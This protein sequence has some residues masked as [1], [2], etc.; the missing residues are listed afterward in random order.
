MF[1]DHDMD[2]GDEHFHDGA[3]PAGEG[4]DV[5]GIEM[6]TLRSVGID[7]GSSTSHLVFS[8]LTLRREG[9]AYSGQFKV[10]DREVLYRSRI[11][12]TPYLRGTDI[13]TDKIIGFIH[14]TYKE[15]G[16]TPQDIDTGAVVITGEALKKENARPILEFFAKDSGKFIC[17]S[18]GPNH[19]ALL[20]AYGC[21][22]VSLSQDTSTTV[23]N[24]DVGGGTTKLTLI[25]NGEVIQTAAVEVGARLIAFDG[26]GAVTRIENPARV[27]M[28]Q[29]GHPLALGTAV[30]P[31]QLQSYANLM[32]QTLF[33]VMQGPKLSPLA[34]SLMLTPALKD[35]HGLHDIDHVVFSGGVSEYIYG[36]DS[37]PY[38]DA[39]PLLGPAIRRLVEGAGIPDLLR[40]PTEGIRATVIGAGEYTMQASGSTSFLSSHDP[41]PV[42]GLKVVR[43]TMENGVTV[44]TALRRAMAKFDLPGFTDGL[45]LALSIQG[46]QNYWTLRSL[47]ESVLKVVSDAESPDAP[48]FV[49]LDQDVAKS[50]GGILKE[51]LGLKRELIV[52]DGIDVGDLDYLDIG[53]PMGVSEVVPVTVKS[54]MFPQRSYNLPG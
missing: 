53:K 39:G 34:Q 46:Q 15:A 21:G 24:V 28:G 32:A 49:V 10:T 52:I 48:L 40:E 1:D 22:A 47:A 29:L 16:F 51:E 54:L 42:F 25:R 26:A 36:Y 27:F 11:T 6:F 4:L 2:D 35:V 3:M 43:P 31:A 50:L 5:E 37:V 23:L 45:A 18:A 12:L 7:I 19:E 17:A 30:P 8:K 38:G 20:A 33:E 9:A 14:E 41:L 44:E 13:D